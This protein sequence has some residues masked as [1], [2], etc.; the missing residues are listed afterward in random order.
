VATLD[1]WRLFR[2]DPINYYKIK[3]AAILA[4]ALGFFYANFWMRDFL[5]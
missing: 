4:K 3:I 1:F 2:H 5:I